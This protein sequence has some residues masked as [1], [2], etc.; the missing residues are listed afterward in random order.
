MGLPK[1]FHTTQHKTTGIDD[2]QTQLCRAQQWEFICS[3][4]RLLSMVM[5]MSPDTSRYKQT[6]EPALIVDGV[7]Q[8]GVYLRRLTGIAGKIQ[9]LDDLNPATGSSAELNTSALELIRE[10]RVLA[11]QTPESWWAPGTERVEADHI[12]QAI[13]FYVLMRVHL[14]FAMRPDAGEEYFYHRLSCMDACESIAHRYLF[15]RRTL[16]AGLFLSGIF[17][18]QVFSATVVLLLTS[19]SSPSSNRF[20][21]RIDKARID[22]VVGQVIKLMREQSDGAPNSDSAQNA[23]STLYALNHLLCEDDSE[24]QVHQLTVKVPLLGK[25]H[26]RRNPRTWQAPK[27]DKLWFQHQP[28]PGAWKPNEQFFP[29]SFQGNPAFGTTWGAQEDWKLDELSWSIENSHESFF[30]DSLMMDTFDQ[31]AM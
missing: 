11:S 1:T 22:K 14:P 21:L 16:P 31:F 30:Q 29:A 7:V 27:A 6:T 15:L 10:L 2:D 3:A 17:D 25:V 28:D 26:V 5:N 4:D 23:A 19:H 20:N 24:N 9:Q 13:H 12:V 8:P 18:F